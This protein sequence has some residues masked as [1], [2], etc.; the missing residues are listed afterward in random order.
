MKTLQDI[1]NINQLWQLNVKK[2][3]HFTAFKLD[4]PIQMSFFILSLLSGS[5][6][7]PILQV[8]SLPPRRQISPPHYSFRLRCSLVGL[9]LCTHAL[10]SG[11]RQTS[12]HDVWAS[13]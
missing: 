6:D 13:L 2:A 5:V 12:P 3:M 4:D 9:V 1:M 11:I 8:S 7:G 10:A